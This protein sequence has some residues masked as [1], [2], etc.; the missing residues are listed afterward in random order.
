MR[1]IAFLI[2][3]INVCGG[4]HKQFLKL[5]DYTAQQGI[6]FVIITK[7]VDLEQAY[8][9]FKKYSTHIHLCNY[10]FHRPLLFKIR[11]LRKYAKFYSHFLYKR[12]LHKL[13]E[14][15][16]VIN[17]HD[18]G[19]ERELAYFKGKRVIWQV[20]DLPGCFALGASKHEITTE[21]KNEQRIILRNIKYVSD[22][23]VNVSK[24]AQRIKECFH[25]DAKVFYCGIEPIQIKRDI[26]HSFSRFHSKK[27]NLLSS[28]VFFRYRNYE[29]Q[30]EVVK[31]LVDIGYDVNLHIIGKLLDHEY[32]DFIQ[33]KIDMYGLNQRIIIEGQV[34]DEKFCKLHKDADIFLFVNI[35][36]SWGLAVFEAM[37]CGLPV[38]VSDSVGATEILDKGVNSIF[39]NPTD[40]TSIINEI[41]KLISS[42][43]YY[44]SISNQASLFHK[45]W[46]WDQVYCSKMIELMKVN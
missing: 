46:G 10:E 20:N 35:D 7:I 16:D 44:S 12:K 40:V 39:V 32:A 1:R 21:D 28:G 8:P 25:R 29:T 33:Y 37:S 45:N 15:V 19:W 27:V 22:F 31:Q 2:Y 18:G 11:G 24:N 13:L 41:L 43:E 23:T 5:L 42:N 26:N 34:D 36:Q 6:S 4:T 38:I 17:I 9:G 14:G 3:D 30:I